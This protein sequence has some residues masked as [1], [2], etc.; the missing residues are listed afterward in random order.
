MRAGGT[1]NKD[2]SSAYGWCPDVVDTSIAALLLRCLCCRGPDRAR[3]SGEGFAV[4][5]KEQP[6]AT[7]R[8][9]RKQNCHSRQRDRPVI[10][11]ASALP[12]SHR[13]SKVVA[14]AGR[15]LHM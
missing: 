4:G 15:L 7:S 12:Q 1:A 10:I 13:T 5:E 6:R 8:G 14:A 9:Q 3:T 2:Y 11:S